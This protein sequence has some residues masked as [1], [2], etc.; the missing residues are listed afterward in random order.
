M[1][2]HIT[3]LIFLATTLTTMA[4]QSSTEK[5]GW[6]NHIDVGAVV[7]T[8]GIGFDIATP[9]SKWASLRIGGHW[10]PHVKYTA[11]FGLEVA[12][13]LSSSEQNDRFEKLS[14]T[15]KALTGQTLTRSVTLEGDLRMNNFKFLV[16]IFPVQKNR[17]F[18][19]TVGFYYG[20]HTLIEPRND[21]V[22]ARN[23]SAMNIYNTLYKRALGKESLID[24]NTIGINNAD[25]AVFEEANEKLRQWGSRPETTHPKSYNSGDVPSDI[26]DLLGIDPSDNRYFAE[27]GVNVLMGTM[28]CD[29]IAD[30][31]IYYD[32]SEVLDNPYYVDTDDGPV[33]V[34]YRTD[35]NGR[36]I[37]KGSIRYYKG[38]TVLS[39]GDELRYVPD[40][41]NSA[42]VVSHINRFKPYVGAGYSFP[43]TKDKRSVISIDAGVMFWGGVPHVD[44]RTPL[45]ID[46]EG[47]TV[48]AT[49][50]LASDVS[51]MPSKI[52]NYIKKIKYFPVFPEIGVRFS[53]RLW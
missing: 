3:P 36:Q 50:N 48:Y 24:F 17:N 14:E 30:E 35:A 41:N 9:M 44:V 40:E 21:E 18:H 11:N 45:G 33:E 43:I 4:Q 5:Y 10:R 49:V 19:V 16:D 6:M 27:F 2:R 28:K 26:N 46:A 13:G 1:K 23:L 7:S 20:N 32:Y 51:N 47:N 52:D 15:M 12:E 34:T 22:S 42:S 38:E 53:Q 8:S 31:D 39:S 37:R 29:V 25:G